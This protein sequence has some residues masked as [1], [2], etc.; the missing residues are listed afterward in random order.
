MLQGQRI[1]IWFDNIQ[2]HTNGSRSGIVSSRPTHQLSQILWPSS[3]QH[4]LNTLLHW[5]LEQIL[6]DIPLGAR[7]FLP[8]CADGVPL[9]FLF[10]FQKEGEWTFPLSRNKYGWLNKK[11]LKSE[12]FLDL[13]SL[14]WKSPIKRIK[15]FGIFGR[16]FSFHY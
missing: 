5:I 10:K 11:S 16:L 12:G 8:I 13:I 15:Q 1:V 9:K 6:K 14:F 3:L 4:K 2:R 7:S